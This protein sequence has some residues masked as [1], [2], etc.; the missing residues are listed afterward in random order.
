MARKIGVQ[1]YT[2]RE[3]L[4]RDF[5]ST[6]AQVAAIGYTGVE[7]AG[8]MGGMAPAA[9][10][11]FFDGHG[12]T[13]IGGHI[14]FDTIS[15]PAKWDAAL[16]AYG[17]LGAKFLGL[18]AVGPDLRT[19]EGVAR[20]CDAINVAAAKS[21]HHGITFTYHNHDF[22]FK[23]A[24]GS[25]SMYD[26]MIDHTEAKTTNFEVDSYWVQYAG[27]DPVALID[28]LAGR[29]AL[30]HIKD[31][32]HDAARGFEIVGDGQMNFDAVLAAGDRNDAAWFI[33]EQDQCPKGEIESITR[34]Y[35][36][37]RTRGWL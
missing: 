11:T 9:L 28:R 36:N 35:A 12:L 20:L 16:E 15:D 13:V 26:Y 25:G 8:D 21:R 37:M 34:S 5:K 18:G 3:A 31:M 19:P 6:V 2:V 24:V 10:R 22:E 7:L 14:G 27:R 33:V 30:I 17:T 23:N 32:T 29:A 1:L 4:K